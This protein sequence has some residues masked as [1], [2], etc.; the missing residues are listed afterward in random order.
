M[1]TEDGIVSELGTLP[2]P[3]ELAPGQAVDIMI[4]PDDIDF[5]PHPEGDVVV[6]GAPVPR[7][8]APLPA[9]PDLGARVHAVQPSTTL[10]PVGTRVRVVANLLHVVAFPLVDET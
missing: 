1:V 2:R 3:P 8:R 10:Y 4:R 9:P 7:G 6:V 5:I